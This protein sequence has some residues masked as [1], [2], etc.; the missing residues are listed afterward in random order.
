MID[1]NPEFYDYATTQYPVGRAG[2]PDD[3]AD[4]IAFLCSDKSGFITGHP[5]V[6]DVGFSI[7]LQ[8]SFGQAQ[9]LYGQAHPELDLG[10]IFRGWTAFIAPAFSTTGPAH[11]SD[12][13][14]VVGW[15]RMPCG[16]QFC[17]TV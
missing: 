10:H 7:Q 4:S 11:V 9:T 17:A 8:D 2:V 1:K 12:L 13:E 14:P 15:R 3:I 5:L 16:S 6:V